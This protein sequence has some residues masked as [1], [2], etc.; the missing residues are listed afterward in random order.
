MTLREMKVR[1]PGFESPFIR[2]LTIWAAISVVC[3]VSGPFGT[4]QMPIIRRISYWCVSNMIAIAMSVTIIRAVSQL[5]MLAPL[6]ALLRNAFGAIVFA[7]GFSVLMVS[8]HRLV[9]GPNP[10][11]PSLESLFW[12][13]ALIALAIVIAVHVL[14]GSKSQ[15]PSG[16]KEP[17]ILKRLKPGLGTGITRL[18]MQD[19]YVEVHTDRGSQLVLMRFSDALEELEGLSGWRLHRSHWIAEDGIADIERLDGKT[20]AITVDG[21]RLPI[22][23]T[24]LPV[25]KEV[26]ILK[27]FSG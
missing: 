17:R 22:S 6:P 13:T 26:G 12:T 15:A 21:T 1:I 9:F 27:R 5:P 19:H 2:F 10:N 20:F 8:V 3:I 14:T 16:I 24:Y 11:Y 4:D 18:A 7:G 23:R 25:L